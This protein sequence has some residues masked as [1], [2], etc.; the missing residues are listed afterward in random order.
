[1]L[2]SSKL[3]GKKGSADRFHSIAPSY[4]GVPDMQWVR[5][6]ESDMIDRSGESC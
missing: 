4:G 2:V 5:T 3:A 6:S 1:M